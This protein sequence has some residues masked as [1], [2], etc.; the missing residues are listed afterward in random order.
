MLY[1]VVNGYR[2]VFSIWS[3]CVSKVYIGSALGW[4]NGNT[5]PQ[6]GSSY[7]LLRQQNQTIPGAN[8]TILKFLFLASLS[9]AAFTE[10]MHIY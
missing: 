2:I 6:L 3:G 7:C 8:R 5:L 1:S 9:E 4:M 10:S